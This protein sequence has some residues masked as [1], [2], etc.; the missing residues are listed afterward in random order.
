MPQ[1]PYSA[2]SAIAC[3]NGMNVTGA[4]TC[5]KGAQVGHNYELIVKFCEKL[6]QENRPAHLN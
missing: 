3:R 4:I 2:C 1:Q 6:S 5:R